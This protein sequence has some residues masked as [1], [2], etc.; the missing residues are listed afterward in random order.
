VCLGSTHTLSASAVTILIWVNLFSLPRYLPLLSYYFSCFVF[1]ALVAFLID[2]KPSTFFFFCVLNYPTSN[3]ETVFNS[4]SSQRVKFSCY[5]WNQS[6]VLDSSLLNS[7]S[8]QN[9][10]LSN[11]QTR[12][13]VS[14]GGCLST[15]NFRERYGIGTLLSAL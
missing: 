3:K 4:I 5:L 2:H 9:R 8:T 7:S 13:R 1:F 14:L 10:L 6:C 15:N 12:I 11:C